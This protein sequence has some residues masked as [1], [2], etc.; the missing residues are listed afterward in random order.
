MPRDNPGDFTS[1]TGAAAASQR[2]YRHATLRLVT[3]G[4]CSHC[5]GVVH[6]WQRIDGTMAPVPPVRCAG[7]GETQDAL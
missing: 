1:T 4:P 6:G 3:L 2:W 7:C 5:G